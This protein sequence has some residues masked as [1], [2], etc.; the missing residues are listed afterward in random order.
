MFSIIYASTHQYHPTL[1]FCLKFQSRNMRDFVMLPN[2]EPY[3]LKEES[4][5]SGND[6]SK[7]AQLSKNNF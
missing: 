3:L 2:T 1:H 6:T 4:I 7:V 5:W